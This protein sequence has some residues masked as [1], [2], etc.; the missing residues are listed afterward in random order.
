MISHIMQTSG[1]YNYPKL[2]PRSSYRTTLDELK[3]IYCYILKHPGQPGP[4]LLI[5]RKDT[6]GV[7]A[8]IGDE[9]GNLIALDEQSDPQYELAITLL[10]NQFHKLTALMKYAGI[11]Q[12]QYFFNTD[13]NLVD[14]Q[15]ALNKF[16][17]PGML[18]DVFGKVVKVLDVVAIEVMN[19]STIC[20]ITS[21]SGKYTGDLLIKPSRYREVE[22]PDGTYIPAYVELRR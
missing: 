8:K 13:L 10:S 1:T 22:L 19:S 7:Y 5:W 3:D 17:G 6:D 15:V 9:H 14:V 18:N 2:L 16:M 12:A 20:E 21:G 4:S 11:T